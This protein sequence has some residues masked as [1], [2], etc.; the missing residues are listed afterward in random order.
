MRGSNEC[1]QAGDARRALQDFF[2]TKFPELA[3]NPFAIT[4]ESYAG[5]YVPTLSKEILDHAPEI[6][7]E[8]IAVGDPCTDNRA[9]QQSMDMLWYSHKHGFVPDA[10][11]T[12]LTQKCGARYPT[13]LAAGRHTDA[14]KAAAPLFTMG[15]QSQECVAAH[16]RFLAS[17]SKGISQDWP[18]AW[19]NDLT[20]YGPAAVV[21]SDQKGSLNYALAQYMMRADVK[22]ALHVTESPNRVWPGPDEKWGYSSNWGA[23]SGMPDGTPSMV[24][25]YRYIAPKL[26]RT[27]VFNGDT[28]PCVSY[29]GTRTAIESLTSPTAHRA[30]SQAEFVELPGG[31]YRPWFYNTSIASEKFMHAKPLLFGPALSFAPAGTLF[32]GHVVDYSHSLSF[33]TVHGSGHM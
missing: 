8:A 6:R 17:T 11:Y 32:G 5:V 12:L 21:G 20:L 26:K 28:D 13:P 30:F 24:D 1:A 3:T 23:C 2:K 19:L 7:L 29:E 31:A 4:G 22:A 15:R 9:Q 18:H 10:D 14:A 33:V 25:F 27:M 16:R